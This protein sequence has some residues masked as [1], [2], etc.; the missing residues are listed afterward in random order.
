M[1]IFKNLVKIKQTVIFA[2]KS[3][4]HGKRQKKH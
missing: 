3:Q 1:K 4:T 2:T